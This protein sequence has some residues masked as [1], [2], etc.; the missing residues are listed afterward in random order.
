[1]FHGPASGWSPTRRQFTTTA[2]AMV[3]LG[4][5]SSKRF[6]S[7]GQ[8]PRLLAIVDDRVP[9]ASGLAVA[10]G[11]AAT[12][13]A[14]TSG[15]VTALWQNRLRGHWKMDGAALVGFTRSDALFCLTMLARDHGHRLVHDSPLES[16]RMPHMPKAWPT[17]SLELSA[18]PHASQSDARFWII[19]PRSLSA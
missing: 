10:A 8:P 9:E 11:F 14:R 1:M 17:R 7:P 3:A 5:A 2:L 12:D 18:L 15:D 6:W 16:G 13:I 4:L 19:A